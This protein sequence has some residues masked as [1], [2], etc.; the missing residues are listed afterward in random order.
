VSANEG[1]WAG[2]QA[3]INPVI[4][5]CQFSR[6]GRL[7]GSQLYSD[8]KGYCEFLAIKTFFYSPRVK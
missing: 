4:S 1:Q 6:A 8:L 7:L 2:V 3:V 5:P